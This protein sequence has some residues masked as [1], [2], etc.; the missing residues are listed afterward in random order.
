MFKTTKIFTLISMAILGFLFSCNP[1]EQKT[2]TSGNL[3]KDTK[4]HDVI[5]RW[6]SVMLDLDKTAAGF[7]P[8]PIAR[9][10]GYIGFATYETAVSGMPGFKS[11]AKNYSGYNVP[12]FDDSLFLVL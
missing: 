2:S 7:R 8:C 4:D 6:N 10:A 5:N 1:D 3:V 11:L 12:K 9:V